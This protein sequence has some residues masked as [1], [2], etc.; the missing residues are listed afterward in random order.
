[1]QD[2]IYSRNVNAEVSDYLAG[3][4]RFIAGEKGNTLRLAGDRIIG[5]AAGK[6]L[7]NVGIEGAVNVGIEFAG[8]GAAIVEGAVT[9][10]IEF[11][12]KGAAIVEGPVTVGIEFASKGEALIEGAVNVAIDLAGKGEAL[13]EGAVNVGVGGDEEGIDGLVKEEVTGA[14]DGFKGYFKVAFLVY[15][16]N[17]VL[18]LLKDF[19]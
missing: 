18:S 19:I 11:A 17:I 7:A 16:C 4:A 13:V 12:G 2:K 5:A 8:K 1:V 15:F 14:F 9:V 3:E 6:G 10:G